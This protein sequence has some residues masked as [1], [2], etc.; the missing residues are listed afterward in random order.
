M[1]VCKNCGAIEHGNL[2]CRECRKHMRSEGR[3]PAKLLDILDQ[4]NIETIPP[5]GPEE[6]RRF[7]NRLDGNETALAPDCQAA[8]EGQQKWQVQ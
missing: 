7:L 4:S 1:I 3:A 8:G 6:I 2:T 5:V